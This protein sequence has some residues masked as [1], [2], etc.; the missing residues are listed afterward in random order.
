MRVV[1]S[2]LSHFFDSVLHLL[3]ESALPN[4]SLELTPEPAT[5]TVGLALVD[6]GPG[7]Y[8]AALLNIYVMPL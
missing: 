3:V 5:S 4:K 7:N 6:C 1:V 8:S 2:Q